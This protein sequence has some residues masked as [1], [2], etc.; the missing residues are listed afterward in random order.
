MQLALAI[1]HP[2][3]SQ[4]VGL[5]PERLCGDEPVCNG[6][7][8]STSS[9]PLPSLRR[10]TRRGFRLTPLLQLTAPAF[11]MCPQVSTLSDGP[12]RS[13]R[14]GARRRRARLGIAPWSQSCGS[15]PAHCSPTHSSGI[16]LAGATVSFHCIL[17]DDVADAKLRN[18]ARAALRKQLIA[19]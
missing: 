19:D 14:R 9:Q 6:S 11:S 16:E 2:F 18:A 10:R 4:G 13:P 17:W 5:T 12:A 1:V 7:N 15:S 8:G 3:R